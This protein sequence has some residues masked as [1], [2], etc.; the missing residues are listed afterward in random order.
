[1]LDIARILKKEGSMS[2]RMKKITNPMISIGLMPKSILGH[3]NGSI[4]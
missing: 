2:I 1:M 4:T 3:L